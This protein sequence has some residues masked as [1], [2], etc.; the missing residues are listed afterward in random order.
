[1]HHWHY[2]RTMKLQLKVLLTLVWIAAC[3]A[4][5][6]PQEPAAAGEEQEAA[7]ADDAG[8]G[9]QT[10]EAEPAPAPGYLALDENVSAGDI[11]PMP[12]RVIWQPWQGDFDGMVAG[13][14]APSYPSVATSSTTLTAC[15]R[16]PL[17]T[18]CSSWRLTST[19]SSAA[20]ISRCTL[21]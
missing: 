12:F 2:L 15:R 8:S 21:S 1:M 13:S 9:E 10:A 14:Y 19:R 6:T 4:E 16:V 20:A 17:T 3:G 11:L 5:P 18:C 7:V